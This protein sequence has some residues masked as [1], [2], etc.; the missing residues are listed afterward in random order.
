MLKSGKHIRFTGKEVA[1]TRKIKLDSSTVHSET[2]FAGEMVHLIET[3]AGNQPYLLE[4]LA[5]AIAKSDRTEVSVQAELSNPQTR[6]RLNTTS[7]MITY[8]SNVRLAA[9]NR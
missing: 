6:A 8:G 3:V 1:E 4:K 9:R 5:K 7:P 2:A